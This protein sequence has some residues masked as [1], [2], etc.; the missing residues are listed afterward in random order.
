MLTCLYVAVQIGRSVDGWMNGM[1]GGGGER[2]G[3]ETETETET[4]IN[5]Q[6]QRQRAVK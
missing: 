3:E 6:R 5:T 4:E 2:D 1:D